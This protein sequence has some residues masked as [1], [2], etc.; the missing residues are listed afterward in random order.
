MSIYFR[1]PDQNQIEVRIYAAAMQTLVNSVDETDLERVI[2][3][4]QRTPF[5]L[6]EGWAMVLSQARRHIAEVA[7]GRSAAD[8]P[9]VLRLTRDFIVERHWDERA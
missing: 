5:V 7:T 6:A 9:P 4:P 2:R 3:H 8:N 1:D